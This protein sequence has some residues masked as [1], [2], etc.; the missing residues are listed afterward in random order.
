MARPVAARHRAAKASIDRRNLPFLQAQPPAH[1]GRYFLDVVTDEEEGLLS[2]EPAVKVSLLLSFV[3]VGVLF[4][5]WSFPSWVPA[6]PTEVFP[7]SAFAGSPYLISLDL[8]AE[9]GLLTRQD[10]QPPGDL[11]GHVVAQFPAKFRA[12]AA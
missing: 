4:G 5:K 6:H 1:R 12:V 10:L 9:D 2:A 8:L 3:V 7:T 11:N